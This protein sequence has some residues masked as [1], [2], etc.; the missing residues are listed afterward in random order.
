MEY[1]NLIDNPA[2]AG[3]VNLALQAPVLERNE[4]TREG[5][6]WVTV[7]RRTTHQ[8]KRTARKIRQLLRLED[9]FE[10][11][12]VYFDKYYMIRFPRMNISTDLDII[13]TD[14]DLKKQVGK[15][16]KI[17]K[18]GKETLLVEASSRVQSD[19]IKNVIKLAGKEVVVTP[20]SR[21][22]TVKGVVRSK[23]FS[24][25]SEE[26][27]RECLEGQGVG[28]VKRVTVKRDGQVQATDTYV[29]TFNRT[30]LPNTVHLSDWHHE[31]VEEY[32]YRPQQ[33]F[34][35]QK[36]GHVAKYCRQEDPVCARCGKQGHEKAECRNQMECANCRKQHYA[37]DRS[38]S[39]YMCEEKIINKQMKERIPR[40]EAMDAIFDIVPE[41]EALYTRQ[42]YN[43][44]E[45][46]K[47]KDSSNRA[48]QEEHRSGQNANTEL[49]GEIHN[50]GKQQSTHNNRMRKAAYSIVAAS[51][52]NRESSNAITGGNRLPAPSGFTVQPEASTRSEE[53]RDSTAA[54]NAQ[55]KVVGKSDNYTGVADPKLSERVT[56]EVP[57]QAAMAD[58]MNKVTHKDSNETMQAKKDRESWRE[59]KCRKGMYECGDLL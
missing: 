49:G 10:A 19:K 6:E 56:A 31:L 58:T 4:E 27:I 33:C 34:H 26:S 32:K 14:E 51:G 11:E 42:N 59:E 52:G 23:A 48:N 15:L 57:R 47:E 1:R 55:P 2:P 17:T 22:N 37:N 28:E 16:T 20:H 13:A 12:E 36:Y 46:R 3:S 40:Q 30:K 9:L 5:N 41:Y 18:A 38:C 8:R 35:C 45:E 39:K 43:R 44:T 24:K 25:S 53:G 50:T 29:L 21:Y 7:N 54:P